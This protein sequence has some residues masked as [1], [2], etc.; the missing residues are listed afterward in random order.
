[1]G[2]NDSFELESGSNAILLLQLLQVMQVATRAQLE[3]ITHL[4]PS[5]VSKEVRRLIEA[6][7][8][9]ETGQMP[10]MGGRPTRCLAMRPE[11]RC[12]IGAEFS[13]HRL[14]VVTTDLNAA[15]QRT[16]EV[17]ILALNVEL[18]CEQLCA[19]LQRAIAE[20]GRER[21]VG[22]G[23]AVP[24]VAD[25]DAG[26]MVIYSDLNLFDY[27]LGHKV[28][29]ATGFFPLIYNRSTS[30]AMG[31]R[32]QGD[33]RQV[34]S[35]F[36]IALDAGISGGLIVKGSSYRGASPAVAEIGHCTVLPD[37]PICFC[38]NRG[39]LQTVAST[40]ALANASRMRAL[41]QSSSLRTGKSNSWI[42][43]MGIT[44]Q[45]RCCSRSQATVS[46]RVAY[47]SRVS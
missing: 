7:F 24:G 22:V 42:S 21:V 8:A 19:L 29:E 17:E 31:E 20:A 43:F 38:G 15:V 33:S 10:S 6:G 16:D 25:T 3:A 5:T 23:I 2:Q 1:M 18:I 9:E 11:A 46:A 41:S 27:P 44:C 4:S 13:T 47:M 35:L 14:R 37:G 26:R 34:Q 28:Q 39:C 32:W 12:A 36:Y 40:S 30:A 45:I